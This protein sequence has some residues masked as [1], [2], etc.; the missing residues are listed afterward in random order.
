MVYEHQAL[1]GTHFAGVHL[2]FPF[3]GAVKQIFYPSGINHDAPRLAQR[4]TRVAVDG[5][6]VGGLR[7]PHLPA[8]S[9]DEGIGGL[10]AVFVALPDGDHVESR[11]GE[12]NGGSVLMGHTFTL[13]GIMMLPTGF[14]IGF[15]PVSSPSV[16]GV[17]RREKVQCAVFQSDTGALGIRVCLD[18][19][20]RSQ[21]A[22]RFRF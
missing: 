1:D 21:E 4:P 9:V 16:H 2:E 10:L 13:P 20:W 15:R 14:L 6:G 5:T 19:G 11:S 3:D 8:L 12:C 22:W 18:T 17:Y 7:G